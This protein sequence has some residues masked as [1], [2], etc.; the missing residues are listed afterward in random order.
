LFLC[1]G[2]VIHVLQGEQDLRRMG[3]LLQIMPVTYIAMLIASL[4]IL[5]FPFLSGFYSKD[6]L[7]EIAWTHYTIPGT[8]AFWL[9]TVS[10]FLT[11]FYSTRLLFFVF[12]SR[13]NSYKI[14]YKQ[15]HEVDEVMLFAFRPLIIGSIF[16]GYFIKNIFISFGAPF[17]LLSGLNNVNGLNVLIDSE[18]LPFFIK[19]IPV[20]FSFLG[21]LGAFYLYSNDNIIYFI[22][23]LQIK[24]FFVKEL[25][26]FLLKK[27]YFDILYNRYCATLFY[28][29][30]IDL[31][32]LGD[33]GI[34]E[35][36]GP[37]GIFNQLVRVPIIK[38]I[39]IT[40]QYNLVLTAMS[41]LSFF[42]IG[43]F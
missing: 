20:I 31:Y 29:F 6:I 30:G 39:D 37:Q 5:G 40:I 14:I 2:A 32:K 1:A 23:K 10:A 36:I 41:L 16:C 21:L 27:W 12:L 18:F 25:H 7:I 11:A 34:L 4:S 3:G 22:T 9:A 15:V 26:F 33:Q 17:F 38:T 13:P 19:I 42:V 28:K 24:F 35:L 8:F 43:F